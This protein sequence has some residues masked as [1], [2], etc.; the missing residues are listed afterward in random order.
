MASEKRETVSRTEGKNDLG[1][2]EGEGRRAGDGGVRV[3]DRWQPHGV[4]R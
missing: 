1:A 3:G 4:I 2:E